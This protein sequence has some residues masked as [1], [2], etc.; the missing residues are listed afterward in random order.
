M[1]TPT[2]VLRPPYRRVLVGAVGVFVVV[3]VV[4]CTPTATTD[5]QPAGAAASA[6]LAAASVTF[7]SAQ[8]MH[9]WFTTNAGFDCTGDVATTTICTDDHADSWRLKWAAAG[10]GDT[11]TLNADC[12]AGRVTSPARVLTDHTTF[13]LRPATQTQPTEAVLATLL[14]HGLTT[15]RAITYCP[16][17]RMPPNMSLTPQTHHTH[18]AGDGCL[19]DQWKPMRHATTTRPAPAADWREPT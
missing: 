1:T 18:T 19:D 13:T 6:P 12:T 10:D 14:D 4:G 5:R 11:G 3:V 15:A 7:I 2:T 16:E 9:D 8:D 17:P